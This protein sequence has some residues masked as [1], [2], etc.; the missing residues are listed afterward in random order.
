VPSEFSSTVLS[1]CFLAAT[2][3]LDLDSDSYTAVPQANLTMSTNDCTNVGPALPDVAGVG[4]LTSFAGQAFLSLAL[5]TWFFFVSETGRLVPRHIQGPKARVLAEKRLDVFSEMLMI[6]NDIQILLGIAYMITVWTHRATVGLYHLRLA[7]EAVSLVGMSSTSA[8]VCSEF[9]H[10][11]LNRQLSYKSFRYLSTYL[12]EAI[13]FALTVTLLVYL[14]QWDDASEDPGLCYNTRGIAWPSSAHPASDIIYVVTLTA[15]LLAVMT[16]AAF[17]NATRRKIIL[18]AT[19]LQYPVH[20]YFMIAIRHANQG[21]LD[22]GPKKEDDWEF[23]QTTAMVLLGVAFIELAGHYRDY[24]KY[25]YE[26][27]MDPENPD[28]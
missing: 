5:A 23:G 4:I 12:F 16:S 18:I 14:S 9:A 10:A 8:L 7:Y 6:G 26:V 25:D 24:R 17:M 22:G 27:G 21:L 15:S 13:F 28:S 11:K 19:F 3:H 2:V 20:M 1:E